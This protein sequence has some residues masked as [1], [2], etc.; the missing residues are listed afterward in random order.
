MI[1]G[2]AE[3]DVGDQLGEPRAARRRGAG[4]AQVLVDH[5]DLV[6]GPA[7]YDCALP[8]VILPGQGLEGII[9]YRDSS[10]CRIVIVS[11]NPS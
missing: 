9:R 11:H 6:R 10:D 5:H 2:L 7:E 4:P 3:P 1:P 8:Q